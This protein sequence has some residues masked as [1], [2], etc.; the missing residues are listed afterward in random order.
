MND[1]ISNAV[2]TVVQVV[3]CVAITVAALS[4]IGYLV[5]G[6]VGAQIG[7]GLALGMWGLAWWT[8]R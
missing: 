5:N 6:E 7:T 8:G 2:T 4:G 1:K 3:V